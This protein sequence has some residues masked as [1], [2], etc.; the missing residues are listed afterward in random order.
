MTHNKN[1]Q[2]F[3]LG[4]SCNYNLTNRYLLRQRGEHILICFIKDIV[5]L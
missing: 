2:S 5:I 4:V 3:R 1:P